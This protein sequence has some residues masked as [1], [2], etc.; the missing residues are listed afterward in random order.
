[1]G[2]VGR[3]CGPLV[4]GVRGRLRVLSS[5]SIASGCCPGSGIAPACAR[6]WAAVSGATGAV[7]SESRYHDIKRPHGGGGGVGTKPWWLAL[8]ACGGAYWGGGGAYEQRDCVTTA[9]D[10]CIGGLRTGCKS[11]TIDEVRQ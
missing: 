5:C 9:S 3:P 11:T 6:P 4:C 8:L 10:I 7:S 2:D 1:M